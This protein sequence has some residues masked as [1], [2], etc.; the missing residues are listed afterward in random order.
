MVMRMI[1]R[2]T[3]LSATAASFAFPQFA[4]AQLGP[5]PLLIAKGLGHPWGMAFLPDGNLLVTERQGQ[6]RHITISSAAISEP[7]AGVPDV[8][9]TGQGGLLDVTLDP[10]FATSR[11]VF[12]SFS[13]P[14]DGGSATAVFR[15]RLSDDAKSLEGG[16]IIFT[17]NIAASTGQ[18]F[19]SRLVFDRDGQLFVTT[20]DRNALR[21]EVQN[22]AVHVGKI[23]RI[24]KDGAPAAGNPQL[25]GWAPEIWSIGHRNVQGAALHPATGEL[26]A[27]EH[28]ARGG[29]EINTPQAGRNYG[30]PIISYGRE[31]SGGKIG[32]GSA[33]DGM[34]QPLHYWDPSIAPS[35]MAFITTDTYPGWNGS[36]LVGAL[37]G[38]H[39]ARLTL[40]GNTVTGEEK[41]F[42]GF[43][44]FRDVQQ[45]PDGR[46]YALTDEAAPIGGLYVI[47]APGDVT[48]TP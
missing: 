48:A 24:S 21:H 14:V 28:G 22:P 7:I 41:L 46:I 4:K 27:A 8:A 45:G 25:T 6:L 38:Q 42:T 36:L 3:F 47:P 19:G 2:R 40:D 32:E 13:R 43:G 39:I 16:N 20:G 11:L 12:L 15:A 34:Q 5:A 1:S 30:W 35:G 37:A 17:Q 10:D 31:Y 29:D 9:A 33:R 26:W 44:R 23:L 18:H